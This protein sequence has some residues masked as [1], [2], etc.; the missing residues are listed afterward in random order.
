MEH[1][2]SLDCDFACLQEMA[3]AASEGDVEYKGFLIV[4]G[5][6]SWRRNAV[7]VHPNWVPAIT[8]IHRGIFLKY[9]SNCWDLNT[10]S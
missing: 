7:I 3:P 5:A 8:A 1:I 6:G 4:R 2:C 9:L 10:M